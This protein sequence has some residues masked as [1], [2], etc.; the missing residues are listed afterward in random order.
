MKSIFTNK[1]GITLIALVVTIIVLLILAGISIMMLTGQNGILIRAQEAGTNTAHAEVYET[2]N[3]ETAEYMTESRIGEYGGTL[4]DYLKDEKNYIKTM[5]GIE[6]YIID[7]EE[8]T[9][10]KGK[11]GN[12]TDGKNDVYKLEEIEGTSKDKTYNVVYYEKEGTEGIILG[13]LQDGEESIGHSTEE[14]TI[15]EKVK[16]AYYLEG[17]Y[18][19]STKQIDNIKLYVLPS[20]MAKKVVEEYPE[21]FT[22]TDEELVLRDEVERGNT[23]ASTFKEYM[24]EL[25]NQ[26]KFTTAKEFCMKHWGYSED[27]YNDY[28]QNLRKNADREGMTDEELLFND[29]K[30]TPSRNEMGESFSEWMDKIYEKKPQK[31]YSTAKEYYMEYW[32][33][34]EDE[35]NDYIQNL[36]NYLVTIT[37][38][39]TGEKIYYF[40]Y[41]SIDE[42]PGLV[43][44]LTS[45]KELC[46]NV[47][48]MGEYGE[49]EI[50]VEDKII[51]K[52]SINIDQY[53]IIESFL[54]GP[55]Y[56]EWGTTDLGAVIYDI[57]NKNILTI[58]SGTYES[59][60]G[61]TEFDKSSNWINEIVEGEFYSNLSSSGGGFIK[62]TLKSENKIVTGYVMIYKNGS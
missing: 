26:E 52:F 13:K 30:Q 60:E 24:E 47:E 39:V 40:D 58:D 25:Y 1:K 44:D 53:E 29:Q 50:K 7:I 34:S 41:K 33:D 23:T 12:G 43:T 21:E 56:E 28:I 2:L 17:D 35:Y 14:T 36:K 6:G 8:L 37:N 38:S 11:Y 57:K 32:G 19:E 45:P 49:I 62:L 31:I 27:E 5:E 55:N 16:D 15:K 9:G 4:I 54:P 48:E 46:N 61:T 20:E 42:G 59:Y 10:G 18:N 22:M 51:G 3:L